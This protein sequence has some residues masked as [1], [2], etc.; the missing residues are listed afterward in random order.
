VSLQF[1]KL[2]FYWPLEFVIWDFLITGI[3]HSASPAIFQ[4]ILLLPNF[5]SGKTIGNSTN[6]K[7]FL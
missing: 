5:L 1:G 2:G 3:F 7:P 6:E 4:F